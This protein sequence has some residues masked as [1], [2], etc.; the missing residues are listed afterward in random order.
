MRQ[1]WYVGANP[2]P[3]SRYGVDTTCVSK[4]SH[5]EKAPQVCMIA[6]FRGV[7]SPCRLYYRVSLAISCWEREGEGGGET[8]QG[9]FARTK[10]QRAQFSRAV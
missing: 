3:R 1:I 10:H 2:L 6:L 7:V 8:G 5:H 9:S 4:D